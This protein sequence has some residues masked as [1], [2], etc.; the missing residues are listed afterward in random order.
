M[1]RQFRYL[2]CAAVVGFAGNLGPVSVAPACEPR[3]ACNGGPT[4]IEQAPPTRIRVRWVA[5]R[6]DGRVRLVRRF[7]RVRASV[8]AS[9]SARASTT[10]AIEAPVPTNPEIEAPTSKDL[11]LSAAV[12]PAPVEPEAASPEAASSK[13]ASSK[14]AS[15]KSVSPG[16]APLGA[17]VSDSAPSDQAV[18]A[19]RAQALLKAKCVRCHGEKRPESGLDLRS[20]ATILKGGE[21]GPGLIPGQPDASLVFQRVRD[22]EM[23]PRNASRLSPAEIAT[24]QQWIAAGAPAARAQRPSGLRSRPQRSSRIN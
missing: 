21:S 19:N 9:L 16:R 8:P 24:L 22:G 20:R 3:G 18:L 2:V 11:P 7:Y 4:E 1:L 23:P 13:S 17:V 5:V 10:P 15:S 14:S 12:P 6:E